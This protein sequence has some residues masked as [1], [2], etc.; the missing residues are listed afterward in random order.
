MPKSPFWMVF[1]PRRTDPSSIPAS[2]LPVVIDTLYNGFRVTDMSA[3]ETVSTIRSFMHS[4]TRISAV[5]KL[6]GKEAQG[7][8]DLIDQVCG[9]RL[10]RD[11]VRGTD[12]GI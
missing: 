6:R 5:R 7:L 12:H 4:S 2:S 8:I 9:M 1:F 11:D 10:R 3:V